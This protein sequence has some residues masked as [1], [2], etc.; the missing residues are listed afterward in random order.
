MRLEKRAKEEQFELNIPQ[1]VANFYELFA[2]LFNEF[3]AASHLAG[4]DTSLLTCPLSAVKMTKLKKKKKKFYRR[5]LWCLFQSGPSL[6]TGL[7][8]VHRRIIKAVQ[9]AS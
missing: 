9:L 8:S 3:L 5:Q 1:L 4:T 2:L 7:G 6:P